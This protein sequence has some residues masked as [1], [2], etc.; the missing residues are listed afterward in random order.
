MEVSDNDENNPADAM[1]ELEDLPW[2]KNRGMLPGRHVQHDKC[3]A[4]QEQKKMKNHLN[5]RMPGQNAANGPGEGHNNIHKRKN[6]KSYRLPNKTR[7]L[8]YLIP[9]GSW[10]PSTQPTRQKYLSDLCTHMFLV[11]SKWDKYLSSS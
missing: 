3:S 6:K 11:L 8:I 4:I 9:T 2:P 5:N 7:K 1:S 10:D